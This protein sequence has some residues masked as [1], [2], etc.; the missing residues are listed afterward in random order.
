[1]R[2]GAMNLS[3]LTII[4]LGCFNHNRYMY[5]SMTSRMH[6]VEVA[7]VAPNVHHRAVAA[8]RWGRLHVTTGGEAPELGAG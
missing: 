8:Q 3:I 2:I 4:R 5:V 7:V 1:M 6:R